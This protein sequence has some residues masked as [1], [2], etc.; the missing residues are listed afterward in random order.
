MYWGYAKR[1][2]QHKWFVLRAGRRLKVSWL[3]LISHDWSKF[4]P[5]EFLPYAQR[6]MTSSAAVDHAAEPLPWQYAWNQHQKF[7]PHHWQFWMMITDDPACRIVPLPIPERYLR[8]MVADWAGASRTY[9][10]SWDI[11]AWWE[12][13]RLRILLHPSSHD[14]IDDLIRSLPDRLRGLS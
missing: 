10:G 7:Q 5:N 3:Q 14:R 4:L 12:R 9:S 1:V 13:Q 8:E 11:A 2:L 6:F